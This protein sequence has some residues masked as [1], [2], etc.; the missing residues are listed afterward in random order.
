MLVTPLWLYSHAKA[1]GQLES[2]ELLADPKGVE[3]KDTHVR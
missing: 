3:L 1:K 2:D